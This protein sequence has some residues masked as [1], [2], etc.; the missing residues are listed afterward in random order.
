MKKI[1]LLNVVLVL[2]SLLI[3][4]SPEV[5][6]VEWCEGMDKKSKADW[7]MNDMKAYAENCVFRK[8]EE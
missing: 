6:S 3:G 7:T 1:V 8:G 4:C 5:G 2:W